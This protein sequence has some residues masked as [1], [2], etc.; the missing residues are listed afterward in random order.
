[1]CVLSFSSRFFHCRS[2]RAPEY[3][4]LN[5]RCLDLVKH[6]F[7]ANKPVASI[8][9]GAQLLAAADVIKGRQ[10]T[11]YPA[12]GP[13]VTRAGGQWMETQPNGVIVDG[14]LVS[15]PA[16]P[17]HPAVMAKFIDLLG[18]QVNKK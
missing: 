7:E 15:G 8:C 16:W 4:R 9:H 12:C 10:C 5:P 18:F 17:S 13:E 1:V 3:L 11:A 14:N 2:G 6:F